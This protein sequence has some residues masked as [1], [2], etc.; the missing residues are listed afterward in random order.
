MYLAGGVCPKKYVPQVQGQI[1]VTGALWGDFMSYH[2]GLPP[3]LK[4]VE[5][6]P[7]YQK[8][9]D[10]HMPTF[11]AELLA[12][13]DRL[14]ELGVVPASEVEPEEP[15]GSFLTDSVFARREA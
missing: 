1:W 4:R 11:I 10:E 13:R 6:D 3:F 9:L 2:P 8:A 15:T 14:R 5:P 12:G 7:K